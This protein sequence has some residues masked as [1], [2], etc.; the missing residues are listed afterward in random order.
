MV[1]RADDFPEDRAAYKRARDAEEAERVAR[2]GP[3]RPVLRRYRG[4]PFGHIEMETAS[5]QAEQD[6]LQE[7]E[8]EAFFDNLMRRMR[9]DRRR[10]EQLRKILED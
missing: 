7:A 1:R 3:K 4:D 8:A 6:A 2:A 10:R 9:A 5:E